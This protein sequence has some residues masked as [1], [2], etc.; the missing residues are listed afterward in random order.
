VQ[1]TDG[2]SAAAAP[3]RGRLQGSTALLSY[4]EWG[5]ASGPAAILLHG[6]T[7]NAQAWWRVAP[8]LAERGLRVLAFDMPG[9][10]YSGEVGEHSIHVIASLIADA[11]RALGVDTELVIGHSWGGSVAISLAT[12]HLVPMRRLVLLDPALALT[13]EIGATRIGPFTKGMGSPA[14]E[15]APGI[16]ASNPDWHEQ[17]VRWKASAMEQCRREAV[18]GFFTK[19]GDWDLTERLSAIPAPALLLLA[20]PAASIIDAAG[21]KAAEGALPRGKGIVRTIPGTTHNMYRGAGYEPTL[22]ALLH[23]LDEG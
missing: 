18:V 2:L 22:A 7:S 13:A 8:R 4:L 12:E 20:D 3:R 15:L 23:W 16:A 19:S 17:D 1:L 5:A 21:A 14:A 11:M 9:H 10:G 6:I